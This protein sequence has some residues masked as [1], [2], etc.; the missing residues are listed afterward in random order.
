MLSIGHLMNMV[1]DSEDETLGPN[2]FHCLIPYETFIKNI[3]HRIFKS[4]IKLKKLNL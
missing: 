3:C 4:Y 1:S 2:M